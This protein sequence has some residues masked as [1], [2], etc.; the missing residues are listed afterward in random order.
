MSD[1]AAK[2]P[3]FM[4]RYLTVA[5]KRWFVL[6]VFMGA[7]FVSGLLVYPVLQRSVA[8]PDTRAPGVFW[9]DGNPLAAF[10]LT[11][12][13]QQ[14]FTLANLEGKWTFLFFGYTNC[15][16]VCP[17]T[18]AVLKAVREELVATG[19]EVDNLQVALVSVDPARDSRQRL[20]A[21]VEHF[22]ETFLGLRGTEAQI[23]Y[24]ARQV[25]AIHFR[26]EPD[27]NG[28]YTVDHT[29][30]ILLIDPQARLVAALPAP[31]EPGHI[32][33]Q[34]GAMRADLLRTGG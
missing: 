22:D 16:D 11:D 27:E 17:A 29:T 21:Y 30:S 31:H 15:P 8:T 3:S 4:H 1:N 25:G 23:S 9:P 12:Q 28:F 18:L 20:G 26:G 7:A 2:S 19:N 6:L 34:V 10:T 14:P 33:A 13:R 24:L 32:A 5:S